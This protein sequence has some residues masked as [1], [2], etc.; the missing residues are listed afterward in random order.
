MNS[1]EAPF[2]EAEEKTCDLIVQGLTSFLEVATN[3]RWRLLSEAQKTEHVK[4]LLERPQVPQRTAEWYAQASTVLTASEFSTRILS[5]RQ[6]ANLVIAKAIPPLPRLTN[7]LA[8]PTNEMSPFDWGIRFEPVVKQIFQRRW[9]VKIV[10]SGR[11]IHPTDTHL[12]ASP[13][14][15]LLEG[16][17][18]TGRL[19]EIKCPISRD[20]GGAI[21]FDYWCQNRQIQ[22]EVTDIDECEYLEVKVESAHPKKKY[23]PENPLEEGLMW[24][25]KKE[26]V[27]SSLE[28]VYAY[29]DEEFD[30]LAAEGWTLHEAIPWALATSTQSLFRRDPKWFLDTSGMRDKFWKDVANA[31]GGS[32]KVPVPVVPK[33]K[34]C[35]IQDSPPDS[36]T[37]ASQ[38]AWSCKKR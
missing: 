19:I 31:R 20:I 1:T 12:A 27:D 34:A 26:R 6:Y 18:R 25:L 36:S 3:K 23:T 30:K 15:L 11:I 8:C 16:G 10:D 4:T 13:D 32:F 38:E 35:L 21:P 9:S 24:L 22:M 33:P 37:F 29:T 28:Y 7:R 2:T 5:E 14:G 17:S